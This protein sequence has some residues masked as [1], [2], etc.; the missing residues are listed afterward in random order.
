MQDHHHV[1][2]STMNDWLSQ[3]ANVQ[4]FFQ[5]FPMHLLNCLWSLNYI[6]RTLLKI[7]PSSN[8]FSFE[9]SSVA[10]STKE[11]FC[12]VRRAI[13]Q[14]V[15][16]SHFDPSGQTEDPSENLS[17]CVTHPKSVPS[18]SNVKIELLTRSVLNQNFHLNHAVGAKVINSILAS[19]ITI[20]KA[21]FFRLARVRIGLKH[22]H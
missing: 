18:F 8:F 5:P 21:M 13:Y 16:E 14:R 6:S 19:I 20:N 22:S 17:M 1:I 15:E 12:L 2:T 11:T 7:N 9:F 10:E 4:Y 3:Q